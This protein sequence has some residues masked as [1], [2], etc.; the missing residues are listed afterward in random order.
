MAWI[1]LVLSMA[2]AFLL[3]GRRSRRPSAGPLD[4]LAAL[5]GKG[6]EE[7]VTRVGPLE[8]VLQL[9]YRLSPPAARRRLAS[10]LQGLSGPGRPTATLAGSRAWLL[11]AAPALPILATRFSPVGFALAVP[12]AVPGLLLPGIIATRRRAR[13][14]R[15]A[16]HDL[17]QFADLLYA[18]VLGGRN[19]EQA[20]GSASASAAGPLG[21]LMRQAVREMELGATREEAFSRVVAGCPLPELSGLLRSLVEA[22]RRGYPV[23][24]TLEVFSREIRFRRS[25]EVRSLVA[26][27]PLKMLAPLVFL[28]L[29]ASVLL[30]VGPT[31]LVTLGRLF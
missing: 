24:A 9:P 5:D 28:I 10:G 7:A 1:F 15:S 17:P 12:A 11:L 21:D 25:D 13:Y 8:S 31:L 14:L 16:G 26:K 19:L 23:S 6:L 27:A 2:L 3:R 18:Y 30:T 22:E 29:P 20:F 4:R